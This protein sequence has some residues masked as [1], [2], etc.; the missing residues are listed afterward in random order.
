MTRRDEDGEVLDRYSVPSRSEL[1]AEGYRLIWYH[2]TRKAEHDASARQQQVDRALLELAEL[3]QKLGSP[4]SRYRERAKV[5][6]AVAA[7]LESRG[8]GGWITIT[9]EERAVEKYHQEG[10]GRPSEQTRYVK[11]VRHA[12]RVEVSRSTMRRWR[13]KARA[14]GSSP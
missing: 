9:I 12:I 3:Q 7:I 2:S 6:A 11:E 8:D 4:R 10:R 13:R 14:M 1:R 5:E